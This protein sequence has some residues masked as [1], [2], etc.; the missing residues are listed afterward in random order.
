MAN[1]GAIAG[2][3]AQS[4]ANIGQAIGAP[5]QRL[6]Q[7]IGGMLSQRAEDRRT[8]QKE[9]EAKALLEQ[10]RDNPAQLR[11]I[12]QEYA[13]K[14]DPLAKVFADAAQI[15]RAKRER[16]MAGLDASRGFAKERAGVARERVDAMGD[17]LKLMQMRKNVALAAESLG[18]PEIAKQAR[19]AIDKEE[20]TELRKQITKE[21]ISR[22]SKQTPQARRALASAA[23]ILPSQFAS[24]NITGISDSEFDALISGQKGDVKAWQNTSGEIKTYRQNDFGMVFDAEQNKWV[25]PSEL[26]LQQ[27]PPSVQ[28]VEN[29]ASSMGPELAK[30]GVKAFSELHTK[31]SDAQIMINNIEDSLPLLDTAITGIGADARLFLSRVAVFLGDDPS[32]VVDTELYVAQAAP[33]VAAQIKALGSGTGLSDADREFTEKAVGGNIAMNAESLRR[34]LNILKNSSK[35]TIDQFYKVKSSIRGSLSE[36]DKSGVDFFQLPAATT[37]TKTVNWSDL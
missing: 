19:N 9:A 16:E 2:M 30:A 29:I 24:L 5:V 26:G 25:E 31:A 10:Y 37:A 22:T 11:A 7:N 28:K 15:S 34:L 32:S 8:G 18:S 27:A 12:A 36:G 13:I 35:G 20:L 6:G 4:G 23:G 3:L 21:Q 33:R 14:Q 17:D 1:I